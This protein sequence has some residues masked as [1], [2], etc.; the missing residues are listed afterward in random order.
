MFFRRRL[1]TRIATLGVL[2]I[3]LLIPLAA[4]RADNFRIDYTYFEDRNGPAYTAPS[5]TPLNNAASNQ[6]GRQRAARSRRR[7]TSMAYLPSPVAYAKPPIV[8]RG[9]S[10]RP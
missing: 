7:P 5:L 1:K 2:L 3:G 6:R 4:G 9:R 8:R 10:G